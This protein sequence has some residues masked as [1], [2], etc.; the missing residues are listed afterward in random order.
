[1]RTI[2]H[3]REGELLPEVIMQHGILPHGEHVRRAVRWISDCRR[4]GEQR[5]ALKLVSEA[6]FRFDLSP[7]EEDWLLHT[8]S[9]PGAGAAR[10][11]D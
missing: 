5:N 3:R 11:L 10:R 8:F 7:L 6:S 2:R 1:V 9:A 4:A